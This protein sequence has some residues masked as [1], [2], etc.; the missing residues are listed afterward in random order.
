MLNSY[1][2]SSDMINKFYSKCKDFM[3]ALAFS[4]DFGYI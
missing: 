4:A 2:A 1:T 3:P